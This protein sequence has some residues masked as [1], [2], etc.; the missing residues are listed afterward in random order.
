MLINQLKW[1]IRGLSQNDNVADSYWDIRADISIRKPL[2]SE[3]K[4]I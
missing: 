2:L 4:I 1:R 3:G